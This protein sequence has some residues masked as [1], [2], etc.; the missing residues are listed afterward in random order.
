MFAIKIKN[1]LNN[2]KFYW[3][4]KNWIKRKP[5]F[6][7]LKFIYKGDYGLEKNKNSFNLFKKTLWQFI[8]ATIY[9][10]V[11]IFL[12]ELYNYAC[13]LNQ[14]YD[15]PAVDTFLS[16]VASISGVFLGL[17]FTAISGIASN[18]LIR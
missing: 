1:N 14:N 11:I 6:W 4:S 9:S 8:W 18:F 13:P 5:V 2:K 17:Y 15:S 10:I 16:A 12:F 7:F 3:I